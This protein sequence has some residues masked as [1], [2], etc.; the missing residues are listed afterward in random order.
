M[1]IIVK[2]WYLSVYVHEF[3]FVQYKNTIVRVRV[4]FKLGYYDIQFLSTFLFTRNPV[5]IINNCSNYQA[6][7]PW[8]WQSDCTRN[9][10]IEFIYFKYKFNRPRSA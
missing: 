7:N 5:H 3:T 1:K 2:S 8:F 4:A 6:F 10:Y 9:V